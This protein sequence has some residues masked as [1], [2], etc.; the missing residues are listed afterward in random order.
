MW[1]SSHGQFQREQCPCGSMNHGAFLTGFLWPITWLPSAR[2]IFGPSQGSRCVHAHLLAKMDSSEQVYR[3]SD[4]T[5]CGVVAPPSLTLEEAFCACVVGKVSLTS[6]MRNT[7]SLY[8]SSLICAGL[9]SSSLLLLSSCWSI[10]SQG[11]NPAAKSAAHLSPASYI[12]QDL[13]SF[14]F[15]IVSLVVVQSPSPVWLFAT[16][17]TVVC[18]TSLSFTISWGL[19]KHC[20][21]SWCCHPTISF[22]VT[23]FSSCPRSFPASESFPMSKFFA[24]GGQT[25]GTSTSAP[26]LPVN[27]QGWF[28]LGLT[29]LIFFLHKGL[30]P[31]HISKH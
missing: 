25:I 13:L 7:W 11:L 19:L 3:Y 20:P 30:S 10:C 31:N 8:L 26:V 23:P 28:P 14:G 16:P 27:I 22:S 29:G 12:Q 9:S 21:L 5:Y 24:S 18:Q 4:I 17:W 15:L 1:T 2:S 6:R